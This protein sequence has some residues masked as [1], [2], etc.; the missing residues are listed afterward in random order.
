MTMQPDPETETPDADSPDRASERRNFLLMTVIAI[1]SHGK[2]DARVRNLSAGGMMI[3]FA[4]EPDPEI[5]RGHKAVAELRN[6]GRVKGEIAWVEG[7]RLGFKFD[8]EIDPEQARKPIVVGEGTPD[9]VKPVLV[10]N[11]SLKYVEGL[12]GW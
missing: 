7:R 9:Y 1:E 4:E 6:I 10:P 5:E 3:E 2:L 8:R 12:K 11:R